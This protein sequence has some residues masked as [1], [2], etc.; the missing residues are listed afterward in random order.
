MLNYESVVTPIAIIL[1]KNDVKKKPKIIC[2]DNDDE[3]K[4]SF[5]E[6]K[7]DK[8]EF[9]QPISDPKLE[10]YLFHYCQIWKW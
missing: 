3:A 4:T 8:D 2:I 5:T 9:F 1:N 6:L 7:L 10:I